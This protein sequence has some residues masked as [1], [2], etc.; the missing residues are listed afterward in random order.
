MAA[1][2]DIAS[3]YSYGVS[4]LRSENRDSSVNIV[5]ELQAGRVKNVCSISDRDR[6][7]CLLHLPDRFRL[8]PLLV[9][10]ILVS[11]END[12]AKYTLKESQVCSRDRLHDGG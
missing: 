7:F 12:V 8:W 1:K 2:I 4:Q 9:W 11:H 6:M 3:L 5:T 10:Q